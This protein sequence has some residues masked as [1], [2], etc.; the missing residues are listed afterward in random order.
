MS[1][2]KGQELT[3]KIDKLALGGKGVVRVN[4]EVI[5]VEGGLPGATVRIKVIRRKKAYAEARMVEVIEPSPDEQPPLCMHVEY[6]GGCVWQRLMY[7]KQLKWKEHLVRETL[8]HLGRL[9]EAVVQPISPSPCTVFYRNKMEFTFSDKRWFRPDEIAMHNQALVRDCGLGLHVK[10]RFDKVFNIEEC[11]LESEESVSI[12]KLVRN[13][14]QESGLPAYNINRHEGFWRFLVIREG[15]NTGHRMVHIITTP[16][17]DEGHASLEILATRLNATGFISTCV[18]SVNDSL[19]QVATGISSRI[20]FGTGYIEELIGGF[21]FRISANSFFQ[22]NPKGAEVLYARILECADLTSS[23]T[24][25]DL[26]CGAGSIS[27]YIARYA[28]RVVGIELIE[29]AVSDAYVNAELNDIRNCTFI[30]GD[31]KDTIVTIKD[32]RP[33]VVITDP[34]RAGMHPNVVKMLKKVKPYKIV[35]VSCNPATLSRDLSIFSDIYY[36][37]KVYPFDLF[38]HTHHIECVALLELRP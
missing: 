14:C 18:H 8:E 26:Y 27:I 15:K 37:K 16:P 3:V 7:E 1:I 28:S 23:E 12:V 25:W 13:F 4:G 36:I 32:D 5:F 29:E 33:E 10:G 20:L 24:V 35:A 6:C 11:Y 9:N 2:K 22:T 34:P 17:G 19:S 21:T 30:A 31:I 38:P